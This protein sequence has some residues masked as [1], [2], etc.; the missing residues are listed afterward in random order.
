MGELGFWSLV[1]LWVLSQ[2]EAMLSALGV[3]Y[4]WQALSESRGAKAE[5]PQDSEVMWESSKH[6]RNVLDVHCCSPSS[7]IGHFYT[8]NWIISLTRPQFSWEPQALNISMFI[9]DQ[10]LPSTAPSAFWFLANWICGYPAT[11]QTSPHLF[12]GAALTS[13]VQKWQGAGDKPVCSACP[14]EGE[15]QEFGMVRSQHPTRK[16]FGLLNLSY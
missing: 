14:G 9:A 10:T 1:L 7:A 2:W 12:G 16:G 8:L 11:N 4:P 15:R 5:F 13:F 3:L 6:L